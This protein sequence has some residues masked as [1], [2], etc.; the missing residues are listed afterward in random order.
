[1]KIY[2]RPYR[3]RKKK[4]ILKNRFFWLFILILMILSGVFY[5][6]LFSHFFEVRGSEI[7]GNQK[8]S[9]ENLEDILKKNIEQ[10]ILFFS[11]KSIF[12]VNLNKIKEEILKEFPQIA[13]VD[14]KRDFPDK[15]SIK[16]EEKKPIAIFCQQRD[17]ENC[18]LI[19]EEGLI[20]D[21]VIITS[22]NLKLPK[23]IGDIKSPDLGVR[24]IEKNYLGLILQIQKSLSENLKIG[25]KEF[26]P[27]EETLIEKKVIATTLEGWQIYF[28]LK[29]DISEQIE[30]LIILLKENFTPEKRVN[31]QYIDLRFE[32]KIYYK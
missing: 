17:V 23:I 22:E 25:M 30:N 9:L 6:V 28:N 21:S 19:E 29:G 14:L 10:K 2:R 3:I 16:I 31:L 7:S 13:K 24:V 8:V 27:F 12:L 18:F 1:M 32:N 11:S 5:L 15:I 20:I 4:S 26:I